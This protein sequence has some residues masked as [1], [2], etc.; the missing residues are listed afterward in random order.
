MF[1]KFPSFNLSEAEAGVKEQDNKICRLVKLLVKYLLIKPLKCLL[2]ALTVRDDR[3][4]S[5]DK[6]V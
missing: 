6:D 2:C 3:P 1:S 4:D 5:Q